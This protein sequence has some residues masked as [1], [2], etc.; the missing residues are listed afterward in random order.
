MLPQ[1]LQSGVVAAC[2]Q[3][4]SSSVTSGIMAMFLWSLATLYG[5]DSTAIS[6]VT[7]ERAKG[8]QEVRFTVLCFI[9]WLLCAVN[10]QWC[11]RMGGQVP[12]DVLC[13]WCVYAYIASTGTA[14][15]N[16]RD[17]A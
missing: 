4:D 10:A 5:V 13:D 7:P 12:S 14:G 8:I 9:L 16:E 11:S 3:G 6:E 1:V 17:L 15:I 2:T